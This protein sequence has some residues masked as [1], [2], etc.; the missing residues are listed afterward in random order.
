[1]DTTLH[2]CGNQGCKDGK[3][4]DTR[5]HAQVGYGQ[6]GKP[7]QGSFCQNHQTKNGE[8]AA[9]VSSSREAAIRGGCLVWGYMRRG[10]ASTGQYAGANSRD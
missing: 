1:M 4:T 8:A 5:I 7:G 2:A 6:Q 10:C 9:R 3:A